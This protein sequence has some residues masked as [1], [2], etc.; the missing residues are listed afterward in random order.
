MK[1]SKLYISLISLLAISCSSGN[2]GGGTP[3]P[4]PSP[5]PNPT[6]S[7]EPTISPEP[8]PDPTIE[9][10]ES[11]S[12]IIIPSRLLPSLVA[13]KTTAQALVINTGKDKIENLTYSLTNQ[14]GGASNVL[15][16]QT[17]ANNCQA[18]ESHNSCVINL[19]VE[20]GSIAGS[21]ILHAANSNESTNSA[22]FGVQQVP[23]NNTTSGADSIT[24]LYIPTMLKLENESNYVMITYII[25]SDVTPNFNTIELVDGSGNKLEQTNLSAHTGSLSS[26]NSG[27]I[28]LRIANDTN[29]YVKT[30]LDTNGTITNQSTGTQQ[31][32]VNLVTNTAIITQLPQT[33]Y[34][35]ANSTEQEVL[36]VNDGNQ[37]LSNLNVSPVAGRNNRI[38]S[39]AIGNLNINLA[40][41]TMESQGG[42]TTSTISMIDPN[43]DSISSFEYTGI[44]SLGN[45]I[46][47]P[48]SVNENQRLAP[49]V[50]SWEEV[51]D[52]S[53]Y[54]DRLTRGNSA[55]GLSPDGKELY[56]AGQLNESNAS[57]VAKIDLTDGT[58][59]SSVANAEI[60]ITRSLDVINAL[61]VVPIGVESTII[62]IGGRSTQSGN[63]PI[64]Y[65][66]VNN[67]NWISSGMRYELPGY[68][69][70]NNYEVTDF[71]KIDNTVYATARSTNNSPLNSF[72]AK[73]IGT[74]GWEYVSNGEPG[75]FSY[76]QL[77]A[78]DHNDNSI[79]VGGNNAANG[80]AIL[81]K[82][83]NNANWEN[84]SPRSPAVAGNNGTIYTL[85]ST[86]DTLYAGGIDGNG[87]SMVL[88][89]VLNSNTWSNINQVLG[90]N[91]IYSL[92]FSESMLYASGAIESRIVST[93]ANEINWTSVWSANT[94]LNGTVTNMITASD[95]TIYADG[96]FSQHVVKLMCK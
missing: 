58:Q 61:E 35:S 64:V 90:D 52:A 74:S 53:T 67:G 50:C 43:I 63:Y 18:I 40:A 62:Y 45:I 57:T 23:T 20:S 11:N 8:S 15:I 88:S 93:P 44:D 27:T 84:I 54:F 31:Y 28:L 72:I 82:S 85:S 59:W 42:N 2:S 30:L 75:N 17:S 66:S 33:L 51:G 79:F 9:P 13:N 46:S 87:Y 1:I 89:R 86:N 29:F 68:T 91:P 3:L 5:S 81:Y 83:T 78:I 73:R 39:T 95:G 55:I 56:V 16:D 12:L 47:S 69:T 24:L 92:A 19:T 60:E 25:N 80:E 7:P 4:S 26:G 77:Y 48:S 71:T 38:A 65:T 70:G 14:K 41:L 49:L 96:E 22:P 6:A 32:T 37:L 21:A 36:L 94:I 34:L 76:A 10:I